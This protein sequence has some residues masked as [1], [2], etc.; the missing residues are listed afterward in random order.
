MEKKLSVSRIFN[1]PPEEVWRLWTE[2]ELVRQWW[3]P[4]K[5]ICPVAK[6]DFR[7]GGVSLVSMKAPPEFGGKET[8]SIWHYTEIVPFQSIEFIMNLAD[9]N[10]IKQDPVS[11]GMPSDFPTDIKTRVSFREMGEGKTEMTVTEYADFGQITAFAKMG[12]E[13]SLGKACSIFSPEKNTK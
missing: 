13:Q 2:P 3:G 10:G 1:A 7:E 11:L 8:Y 6:M 12:L 9:Q 5:F 4:D